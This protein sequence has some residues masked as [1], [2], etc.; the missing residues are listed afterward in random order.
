MPSRT[1][2]SNWVAVQLVKHL[3]ISLGGGAGKG[4]GDLVSGLPGLPREEKQMASVKS[5][6]VSPH[7]KAKQH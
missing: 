1:D 2:C 4:G 3:P 5:E 7:Q 6:N